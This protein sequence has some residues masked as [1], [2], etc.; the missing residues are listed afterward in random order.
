M[1]QTL[2]S[3]AKVRWNGQDRLNPERTGK[4]LARF[5][6]LVAEV[7]TLFVEALEAGAYQ[8]RGDSPFRPPTGETDPTSQA[9]LSPTQRQMRRKAERAAVLIEQA[10]ERLEDAGNTLHQ[11]FLLSDEDAYGRFLEKRL[12]A[13]QDGSHA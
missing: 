1:N 2:G 3:S 11:G 9:A 10:I 8:R 13:E 5:E 12:A 6:G 7:S 4:Q